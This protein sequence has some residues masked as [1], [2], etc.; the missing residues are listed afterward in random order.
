MIQEG[1]PKLAIYN[2]QPEHKLPFYRNKDNRISI[3]KN[4]SS[5]CYSNVS[6]YKLTPNELIIL[7]HNR[8]IRRFSF[9]NNSYQTYNCYFTVPLNAIE[10]GLIPKTCI[11]RWTSSY[12]LLPL[13]VAEELTIVDK[14]ELERQMK[15]ENKYRT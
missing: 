2:P 9:Y 13:M 8:Q 3:P 12:D 6:W 15:S 10:K 14:D 4:H 1:Y 11:D 5:N 7:V